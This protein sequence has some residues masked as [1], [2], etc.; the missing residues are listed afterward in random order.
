GCFLIMIIIL[1]VLALIVLKA[2]AESPWGVF[3]VFSTVPIALFMGIYMRF[4]RPGR[5]GDVSV[6][7]IVLLVESIYFV[8]VLAHDPYWGT[9]LT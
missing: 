3:T 5:V 7:G 9:A 4:L 2:L 8:G 6:I 1:S